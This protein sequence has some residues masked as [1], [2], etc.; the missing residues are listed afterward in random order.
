MTVRVRSCPMVAACGW[1]P[2]WDPASP[3]VVDINTAAPIAANKMAIRLMLKDLPSYMG[4]ATLIN[5]RTVASGDE[6]P[7][8][9]VSF[10]TLFS[11]NFGES[12]K[13]EVHAGV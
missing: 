5:A 13:G 7:M 3:V 12:P 11:P 9:F 2:G 4:P 10:T 8:N 1:S 6:S